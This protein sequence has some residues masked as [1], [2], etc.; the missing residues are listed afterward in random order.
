MVGLSLDDI[1]ATLSFLGLGLPTGTTTSVFVRTT[2]VCYMDSQE[3]FCSLC[4]KPAPTTA[5]PLD[6]LLKG[7]Y[8]KHSTWICPQCRLLRRKRREKKRKQTKQKLIFF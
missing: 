8:I 2:P 1:E 7:W 4:F 6:L 5:N 3:I